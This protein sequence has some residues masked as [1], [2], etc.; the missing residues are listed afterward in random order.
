MLVLWYR[1]LNLKV[2]KDSLMQRKMKDDSQMIQG[3]AGLRGRYSG[4][5]KLKSVL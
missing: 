5:S 4:D 1:V 3:V 2:V